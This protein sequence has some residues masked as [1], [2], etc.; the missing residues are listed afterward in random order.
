MSHED[1]RPRYREL[2][3]GARARKV[4]TLLVEMRCNSYCVFCGQRQVDEGLVKA[5]RGLGLSMPRTS[6]GDLRGRYTLETATDALLAA[7]TV[8][9]ESL[10]TPMAGARLLLPCEIGDYSDFYASIHHAT[11]VGKMF[12]PDNPLLPNYKWLPVGYHGRASFPP[13]PALEEDPPASSRKV[14]AK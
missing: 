13:Q 11:N 7:R 4:F 9:A 1:V 8:G 10:L 12:R 14:N 2:M 3:G 6:Y 5:R